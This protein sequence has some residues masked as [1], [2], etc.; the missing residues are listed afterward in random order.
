MRIAI[1][2][3]LTCI[4]GT[5]ATIVLPP[6]SAQGPSTNPV[7]RSS[8]LYEA[9]GK[10]QGI[11]TIVDDLLVLVLRDTRINAAFNDVDMARLE[12]K[13]VEQLC[14][15]AGGPCHYSGKDMQLIH[16]DL[17]ITTAHFNILTEHLQQAMEQNRVPSRM[18]NKLIAKLAPMQREIVTK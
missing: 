1:S 18:Q 7:A 8:A 2:I 16:Q 13:L 17:A 12:T 14:E 3:I 10:T 9:L 6:A 4:V 5:A 11:A 15:L